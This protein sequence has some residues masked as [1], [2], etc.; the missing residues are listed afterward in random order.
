MQWSKKRPLVVVPFSTELWN[1][2]S[3]ESFHSDE[4]SKIDSIYSS[5]ESENKDDECIFCNGTF[6]EE[7]RGEM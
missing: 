5:K 1:A 4:L 7:E 3:D 2:T 6:S